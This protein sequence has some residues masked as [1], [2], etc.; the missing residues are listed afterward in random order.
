MIEVA[1]FTVMEYRMSRLSRNCLLLI[2]SLSFLIP[3]GCNTKQE[4]KTPPVKIGQTMP[5]QPNLPRE[6]LVKKIVERYT[7]L[8][9]E[10]YKNLDMNPLQE[11][12]TNAEAEK[13]YIHM[14]AIGEGTSRLISQMKKISY[15]FVQFPTESTA[16]VRTKEI[17][18]FSHTD[19]KSGKKTGEIL[20][21]PYDVTYTL[22]KKEGRWLI[23]DI[24]ASS[25]KDARENMKPQSKPRTK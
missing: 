17:W 7:Y 20:D 9:A 22:E 18:D 3:A 11:V 16:V 12:A 14:A 6:E 24:V 25:E 4:P 23:T 2:L 15:E 8:V 19:I 21:F 13:A 5:A 10:G 1:I